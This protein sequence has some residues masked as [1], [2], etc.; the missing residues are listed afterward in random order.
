MQIKTERLI[1]PEHWPRTRPGSRRQ[2]R[3]GQFSFGRSRDDLVAELRRLGASHVTLCCDVPVRHDGLPY[4][5]SSEPADPGIAVRF[6]WRGK[7]YEIACD[8]YTR[9]RDNL[10]AVAKTV[11]AM[12][13]IERHGASQLL[14]RA[15][16]SFT[17]LPPGKDGV[18]QPP[19][20]PWW[21]VLGLP[22]FEGMTFHEIAGD[23]KHALRVHLLKLAE[24]IYRDKIRSAH[25]DK[26]GSP[27][28]MIAL[29][30]AIQQAREALS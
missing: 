10:R 9:A 20:R 15:L 12:R 26:G 3:F 24:V 18:S 28:E 19:R 30:L 1:W 17:A 7:P 25:P 6:H 16:S 27:E 4:A 22:T 8:S 23:P 21:E 29:N 5:N 2:A 11:E 13:A 14:E